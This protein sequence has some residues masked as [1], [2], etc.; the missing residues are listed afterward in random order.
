M[1][2][3][4]LRNIFSLIS[5]V[6]VI[7]GASITAVRWG[8]RKLTKLILEGRAAIIKESKEAYSAGMDQICFQLKEIEKQVK[9]TNGTVMRHSTDIGQLQGA[10]FKLRE[11]V[12]KDEPA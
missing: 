12:D 1:S 8:V 7:V 4:D 11:I 3:D 5:P 6:V 10:V 2:G 9:I